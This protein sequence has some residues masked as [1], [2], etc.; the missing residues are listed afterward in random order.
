MTVATK[1]RPIHPGETL[2]EDFMKPLGL[3]AN[4][5]A[6]A[7]RVPAQQISEI[8]NGQRGI[9]PATAIRLGRLFDMMPMFWLNLQANYE[10]RVWNDRIGKEVQREITPVARK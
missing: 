2:L 6:L 10:L 9:S 8:V 4:R 7:L 1:I 5:L 3:N